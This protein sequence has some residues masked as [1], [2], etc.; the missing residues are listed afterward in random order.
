MSE[1]ENPGLTRHDNQWPSRTSAK[2]PCRWPTCVRR[3]SSTATT[4]A[5]ICCWRGWVARSSLT[6]FWRSTGDS[7]TRLDHN[8]PTLNLSRPGDPRDT[9]TPVA[10]AGTLRRLLLGEVL[11]PES[12]KHLVSWMVNCKTGDNRLRGGLPKN[13]KIGDK[14][15]NNGNDAA[16]DIAVV[17]PK[18]DAP[19]LIC[20]Y[21][22]GGSPTAA[23]LEAI[24]AEIGR[25]V[26]ELPG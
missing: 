15:G 19:V 5:P 22:Q 24:F 10:M 12:R 23:Q 1:G 20:A 8:E 17:W 14:T 25:I 7:V 9:T 2:G 11:S 6:A 26:G 4:P 3:Q 16:G 21:T 18:P 13:W